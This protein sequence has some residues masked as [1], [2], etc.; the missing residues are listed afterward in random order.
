MTEKYN[1]GFLYGKTM[2][3]RDAKVFLS[4]S[5]E[6]FKDN[7]GEY[8]MGYGVGYIVGYSETIVAQLKNDKTNEK[9]QIIVQRM[10]ELTE[11]LNSQNECINKK[12]VLK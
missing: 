5:S 4:P 9:K 11:C 2:G 12:L 6:L 8:E 10:N 7:N 3:V 1:L